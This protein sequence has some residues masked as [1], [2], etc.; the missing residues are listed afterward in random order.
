MLTIEGKRLAAE[1]HQ[2]MVDFFDRLNNEVEG[3]I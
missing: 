3:F 2:F 1:R